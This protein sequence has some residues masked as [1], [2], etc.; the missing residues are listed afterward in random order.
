MTT[1][2]DPPRRPLRSVG[3][4]FAGLVAIFVLSIGTDAVMH[5]SGIFPP[6]G[7]PMANALWLLATGYRLLISVLGCAIAAWLAPARPMAH[8]MA[9]GIVGVVL[10]SI[11][12]AV[13]V[14]K[15]PS[16]GPLW[17]PLSLVAISLPCAWL[18]GRLAAR[19]D[20]ARAS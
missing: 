8:A 5:A 2:L 10:S 4:V 18:G 14:A 7:Q 1:D 6:A 3:A 15:G 20:G 16:L 11:G 17:Y 12:V 19:R 13:A 9:L